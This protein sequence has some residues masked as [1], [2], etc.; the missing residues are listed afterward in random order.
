MMGTL[1]FNVAALARYTITDGSINIS[2][3]RRA[4][5]LQ[6]RLRQHILHGRYV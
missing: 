3:A 6:L 5:N 1:P 2:A 4:F